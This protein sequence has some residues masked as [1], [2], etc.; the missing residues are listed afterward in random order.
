MNRF[1]ARGGLWQH[2]D[3]RR[4]WAGQTVS[5]FG[6]MVSNIAI[7]FA[8]IIEL[9]ASP[10]DIAA[11]RVAQVGPAFVVGL[12]A[13][14]F[15][16]RVRRKP[17]MVASDLL[18]A[19][20]LLLVPLAALA[21]SMSI[22]LLVAVSAGISVLTVMFDIAY[23]AYLPSLVGR[24][25]LVEANS[26]MTA[27]GSVAEFSAFSIGGW[28]VQL[29]T[30]PV[31]IFVDGLTFL[32]SALAIGR[33]E[34]LE[35]S[36]ERT[37]HDEHLLREAAAGVRRVVADS[38]LMALAG[39]TAMFSFS[40][41]IF[42]AVFLLFVTN[43]LEFAPGSLGL[44]F[45]V[46]GLTALLG[47]ML[48]GRAI[49]AMGPRRTM[50]VTLLIVAIGKTFVPISP[51]VSVVAVVLLVGQQLVVDPAWTVFEI[52]GVSTRQTITPDSWLGRVN[53]TFR[54]VEFG[55]IL[56]GTLIGA[57]IGSEFGLR[58]AL[59][60]SVA[61]AVVGVLPLLFASELRSSELAQV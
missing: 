56:L 15:A 53:G 45:A 32:W 48:A 29:L 44:I 41:S 27:T 19:A 46:G 14:A 9:D 18:R 26:K 31:A 7:P 61:G 21:D 39:S 55:A 52:T 6:S 34:Y 13:G 50:I 17:L 58:T 33:V 60:V 51:E 30:A 11:L 10:F 49:D 4:L 8:A 42:G 24:D 28:L 35:E 20:L 59:W 25:S 37:E 43:E 22:W 54:V 36:R 2:Q 23:Q 47:A 57:W 1:L 5:M 38:R 40:S 3:F 12:F 16:D